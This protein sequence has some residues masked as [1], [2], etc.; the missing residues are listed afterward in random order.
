MQI[1]SEAI[2]NQVIQPRQQMTHKGN[3]G[4]VLIV[5]GNAHF[6][7]AAIIAASAAVYAGAGLVTVATDS[8]N[9][10]P[11]HARLPEAMVIDIQRSDLIDA[12]HR[13]TVVVIG[14]GLGDDEVTL[15]RVLSAVTAQQTLVID[16]SA[17]TLYGANQPALPQAH[18]IWTPHQMEWQRLSGIAVADQT[19]ETSAAAAAKLPGIVVAKSHRTMIFDDTD[20]YQNPIGSAALATGGSGDTLAGI[21]GAFNAQFGAHVTSTLAAVYA[22]SDISDQLAKTQFVTLPT[23]IIAQLPQYMALHASK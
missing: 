1:L 10:A 16:G 6:G 18:I 14:P 23:A 15:E 21:I 2:V 5:G 4:R 7:G 11:L 17:I 20:S 8:H 13:A 12:V 22:H 3:F 9:H 19:P